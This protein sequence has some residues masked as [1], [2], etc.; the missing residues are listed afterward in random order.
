MDREIQYTMKEKH[1]TVIE[2]Y[3][4]QV[5]GSYTKKGWAIVIMPDDILIDNY[6][7]GYPHIHPER[8]EIKTK[9]LEDTLNHVL[10]HLEDNKGIN[11]K[12][13]REE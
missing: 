9:T 3:N 11:L 10:I 2:K 7:H 4:K 6:H 13:L 8:E 12:K 5:Y 1:Q